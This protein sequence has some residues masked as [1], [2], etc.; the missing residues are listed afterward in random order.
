MISSFPNNR[1]LWLKD[2]GYF[3]NA[4]LGDFIVIKSTIY[5]IPHTNV[6]AKR[7]E[8]NEK[9]G[10]M[11]FGHGLVG[12][13][14]NLLITVITIKKSFAVKGD[15]SPLVK[16]GV[17]LENNSSEQFQTQLNEFIDRTR[18]EFIDMDQLGLIKPLRFTSNEVKN[19]ILDSTLRFDSAYDRHDFKVGFG[20]N[21]LLKDVLWINGFL[22][23]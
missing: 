6:E 5:Y 18:N 12:L 19:L 20:K 21:K 3:N 22:S 9:L 15:I 10:K 13:L 16:A 2:V 4:Y 17:S 23:K 1:Q 8:A 14:I 11:K 7:A